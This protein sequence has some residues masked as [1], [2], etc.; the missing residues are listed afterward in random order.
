MATVAA[1]GGAIAPVFR[2]AR[3]ALASILFSAPCRIC[4]RVLDT[5]SRVPICES[6]LNSFQRIMKPMC[7]RCGRPMVSPIAAQSLES[8]CHLCRTGIYDFDLAR[9][10]AVYDDHTV[11]AILMLKHEGIP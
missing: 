4:E 10:F 6:C 2:V 11:R 1:G 7:A 5:A 8:L 3:D 9:S